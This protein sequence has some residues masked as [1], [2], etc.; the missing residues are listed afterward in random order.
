MLISLYMDRRGKN[1]KFK[2]SKRNFIFQYLSSLPD[3][4]I[5]YVVT[6]FQKFFLMDEVQGLS[7]IQAI[8]ELQGINRVHQYLVFLGLLIK[9]LVYKTP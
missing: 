4:A 5:L 1:K 2:Q 3:S 8:I 7:Q 6:D 9:N